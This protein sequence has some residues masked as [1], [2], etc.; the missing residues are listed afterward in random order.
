[1]NEQFVILVQEKVKWHMVLT[2]E[3]WVSSI[4]NIV[5]F[6]MFTAT[7]APKRQFLFQFWLKKDQN[8]QFDM[9]SLISHNV[10][11]NNSVATMHTQ[12]IKD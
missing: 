5:I 10:E 4:I 3:N 12:K 8:V 1:M 2:Y 11:N 7:F 9:P 6:D